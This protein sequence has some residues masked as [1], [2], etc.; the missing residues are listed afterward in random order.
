MHLNGNTFSD[1][2]RNEWV[3]G[4]LS[5][6]Y[7]APTERTRYDYALHHHRPMRSS[8][9]DFSDKSLYFPKYGI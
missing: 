5:C 4:E 8:R 3:L 7:T 6:L 2:Q 1:D 9:T